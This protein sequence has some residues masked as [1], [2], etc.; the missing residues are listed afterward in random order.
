MLV[1][2]FREQVVATVNRF[3][4]YVGSKQGDGHLNRPFVHATGS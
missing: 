3:E 1:S 2:R 4:G